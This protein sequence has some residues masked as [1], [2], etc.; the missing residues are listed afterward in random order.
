MAWDD[1]IAK[2]TV[3]PIEQLGLNKEEISIL[4]VFNQKVK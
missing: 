1:E 3:K 2:K 4:N